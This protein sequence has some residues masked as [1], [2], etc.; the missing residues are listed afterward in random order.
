MSMSQSEENTIPLQQES[1]RRLQQLHDQQN[2]QQNQFFYN[3]EEV[4]P[5]Y[6]PLQQVYTKGSTG[7]VKVRSCINPISTGRK[8]QQ[9]PTA[10]TAADSS[11]S[12]ASSSV[13]NVSFP[14]TPPLSGK[15]N[16]R[17]RSS[18]SAASTNSSTN[19]K[20]AITETNSKNYRGRSQ[21]RQ[22]DRYNRSTSKQSI[23]GGGDSDSGTEAVFRRSRRNVL[24][25]DNPTRQRSS[26]VQSRK[27]NISST[28]DGYLDTSTTTSYHHHRGGSSSSNVRSAS[29]T[30]RSKNQARNSSKQPEPLR[31]QQQQFLLFD[32]QTFS[33]FHNNQN[34]AQNFEIRENIPSIYKEKIES[35]RSTRSRGGS[36]I[37]TTKGESHPDELM[38]VHAKMSRRVVD[39]TFLCVL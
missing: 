5:K 39:G 1:L 31:Q 30:R 37:V 4:V 17:S 23:A 14:S 2:Q 11:S 25:A 32:D 7:S 28:T 3:G 8:Q 16:A 35:N 12:I 22:R 13:G 10:A 15:S 19:S 6:P 24:S 18:R 38:K 26:S 21:S 20:S 27:S 36:D 33:N 9:Q 29:L 34:D